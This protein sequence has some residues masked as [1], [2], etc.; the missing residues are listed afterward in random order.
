ML[1]RDTETNLMKH[2]KLKFY[3]WWFYLLLSGMLM[4]EYAAQ[5]SPAVGNS[6][7]RAYHLNGNSGTL[8]HLWHAH[9][10]LIS[11]LFFST[12][13]SFHS[14]Q[15]PWLTTS[16]FVYGKFGLCFDLLRSQD[17][18]G[19]SWSNV[20]FFL[21]QQLICG[22]LCPR[23]RLTG[24]VCLHWVSLVF[25]SPASSELPRIPIARISDYNVG[26]L[27]TSSLLTSNYTSIP[28]I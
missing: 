8:S 22:R 1:K 14:N 17:I 13:R 4:A 19:D 26:S 28:Y 12:E 15:Q 9:I 27:T 20:A 7:A 25:D 6:P 2:S 16:W 11:T 5:L 23:Q 18:N 21:R 3:S 24:P 10:S